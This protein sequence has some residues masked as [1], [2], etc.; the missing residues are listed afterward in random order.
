MM[1][2]DTQVDDKIDAALER[3]EAMLRPLIRDVLF[4]RFGK[5][6]LTLAIQDAKLVNIEAAS[7]HN[8]KL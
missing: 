2:D 8:V 7:S 1:Y 6:I 3:S 5:V 4:K